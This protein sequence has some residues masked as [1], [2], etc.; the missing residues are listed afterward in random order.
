MR[1]EFQNGLPITETGGFGPQIVSATK[2]AV[3]R[4]KGVATTQ[5]THCSPH[6]RHCPTAQH[7]LRT[8]GP[9][10]GGR[11]D[12]RLG[13]HPGPLGSPGSG[14][15]PVQPTGPPRA[16]RLRRRPRPGGRRRLRAGS[17]DL[18]ASAGPLGGV[19]PS[20]QTLR[21]R[22]QDRG[23]DLRAD[24]QP[25]VLRLAWQLE[26]VCGASPVRTSS[27]RGGT[28]AWWSA[29]PDKSNELT[30]IRQLPPTWN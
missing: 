1:D 3:L 28:T 5:R 2:R 22:L 8:Q 30:A 9:P 20:A 12:G 7:P 19:H 26:A 21:R 24:L 15:P 18:A 13:D 10:A 11:P 16:G 23:A 27:R 17:C 29:V 4:L 14:L 25:L 6:E